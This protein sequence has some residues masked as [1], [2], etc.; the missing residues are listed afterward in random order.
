M[1]L[2]PAIGHEAAVAR[3]SFGLRQIGG[4]SSFVRVAEDE[5]TR[6]ARRAVARGRHL[7]TVFNDGLRESIAI[8]EVVVGIDEWRYGV[9]VKRREYLAV[10][11]LR[12]EYVV[13]H[14]ASLALRCI[15]GQKDNDGEETR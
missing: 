14:H 2:Q 12:N 11:A 6:L 3:E 9:Q 15:A 5:F 1:L 7:A 13:L 8:A 10:D 4:R